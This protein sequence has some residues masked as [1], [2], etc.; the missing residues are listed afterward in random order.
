M[1]VL[2]RKGDRPLCT[3][4][5]LQGHTVDRCY[6]LHGYPLGYRMQRSSPKTENVSSFSGQ[7]SGFSVEQCQRL[8]SLLQFHLAGAKHDSAGSSSHIAGIC[9]DIRSLFGSNC[10]IVDSGLQP[11]FVIQEVR[12]DLY[13]L[14]LGLTYLCLIKKVWLWILWGLYKFCLQFFLRVCCL[15]P[16][17]VSICCPSVP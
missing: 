2:S 13:N 15:C 4:C 5:G 12:S 9:H 11:M 3:H 10:C 7:L 8:L 17:F 1:G 6:K 16:A 14:L